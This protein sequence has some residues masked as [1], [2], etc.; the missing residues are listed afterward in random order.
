MIEKMEE[1]KYT[2]LS[3]N[4]G[5]TSTKIALY[6]NEEELFSINIEHSTEEIKSFAKVT[7]QLQFRERAIAGIL[8]SMNVDKTKL[9]AVVGRGGIFPPLDAGGYLVEEKLK[10]MIYGV[11][12]G[13]HASNLG[14]L[15][16]DSIAAPLGIPA[17]IYDGVSSD[18][19]TDVARITGFPEYKRRNISHVLNAKAM[20][21]KY[22]KD[23]GVDYKDCKLIVAHLGGGITVSAHKDGKIIDAVSDDEG[24]FSP[25]RSGSAAL[26]FV[27]DTCFSGKYNRQEM[28]KKVRGGGGLK[29]L[30]G[31]ADC[32]EVEKRISEGDEY[33]KLV[34]DAM[35]Y[36]IGKAIGSLSTVFLGD[37]DG[38]ILTGGIAHS[39][40][41]TKMISDRVSFIAPVHI[42]PGEN[43][44]ESLTMG[45]L[46]ILKG[47]E[48]AKI[49]KPRV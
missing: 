1:K 24:Q 46:R 26:L 28:R 8:T 31:T 41:L 45:G 35:A 17:F 49:Y 22:A 44:M 39:K 34:Y 33:A 42:Y 4:P 20:G 19:F 18:E 36:N 47:E 48:E 12:E 21:R 43:E 23:Q 16:A 40:K 10:E 5:S 27:I 25:E 30:L 14:A 2:I 29:A 6:E 37:V 9:S 7:D 32:R 13:E 11:K 15:I 38:I 3:I